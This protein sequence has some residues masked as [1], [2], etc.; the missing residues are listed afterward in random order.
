MAQAQ[1]QSIQHSRVACLIYHR[2]HASAETTKSSRKEQDTIRLPA[3]PCHLTRALCQPASTPFPML[4]R[5]SIE[6]TSWEKMRKD[7]S[8]TRLVTSPA[9]TPNFKNTWTFVLYGQGFFCTSLRSCFALSGQGLFSTCF[10]WTTP[11]QV[12]VGLFCAPLVGSVSTFHATTLCLG[13]IAV[14]CTG[15][16]LD[17]FWALFWPSTRPPHAWGSLRFAHGSFW[18]SFGP[19]FDLPRDHPMLGAHYGLHTVLFGP[20]SGPVLTFHATTPCLGSLGFFG[21]LLVTAPTFPWLGG[22]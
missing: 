22:L 1:D 15:F 17:L 4:L 8:S 11:H 19:C 14:F 5:L 20:L 13:V 2:F 10:H 3:L 7:T 18:T 21:S 9:Q 16:I 6:A 12:Y